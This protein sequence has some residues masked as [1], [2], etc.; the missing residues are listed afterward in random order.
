MLSEKI[1]SNASEVTRIKQQKFYMK[2]EIQEPETSKTQ[3][4]S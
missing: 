1:M 4:S 2:I 3:N